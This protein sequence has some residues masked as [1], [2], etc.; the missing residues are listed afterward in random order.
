MRITPYFANT[1]TTSLGCSEP[2]SFRANH[3]QGSPS[4]EVVS[5]ASWKKE[6]QAWLGTWVLNLVAS[7]LRTILRWK[8]ARSD[9]TRLLLSTPPLKHMQATVPSEIWRAGAW[10]W[11]PLRSAFHPL[12]AGDGCPAASVQKGHADDGHLCDG[13][14][15]E[16][17]RW[18]D[19]H[20]P[21]WVKVKDYGS[22]CHS[23]A[24]PGVPGCCTGWSSLMSPWDPS[25]YGCPSWSCR[26]LRRS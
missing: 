11:W 10:W 13:R 24:L 3:F 19:L 23:G 16:P 8:Q 25:R 14:E 17:I 7:T 5:A 1:L 6:P 15:V 26:R 9:W 21:R 18:A 22:C 2:D 12:P 20:C 4:W